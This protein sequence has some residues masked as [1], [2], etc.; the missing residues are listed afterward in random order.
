M[1]LGYGREGSFQEIIQKPFHSWA[2][3]EGRR[4]HNAR[5]WLEQEAA[6]DRDKGRGVVA[7]AARWSRRCWTTQSKLP[8]KHFSGEPISFSSAVVYRFLRSLFLCTV[9]FSLLIY[10]YLYREEIQVEMLLQHPKIMTLFNLKTALSYYYEINLW[11][12]KGNL[13]TFV[14]K[15]RVWL[16]WECQISII[17]LAKYDRQIDLQTVLF[18]FTFEF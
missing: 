5:F 10:F 7:V 1:N 3:R 4:R 16:F 11:K 8:V 13:T 2:D 15:C 12:L 14:S 18:V 6:T 17:K 9:K